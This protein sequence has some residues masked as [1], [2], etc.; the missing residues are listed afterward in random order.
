MI[1]PGVHH[2][3]HLTRR[4]DAL[5]EN[6]LVFACHSVRHLKFFRGVQVVLVGHPISSNYSE[7]FVIIRYEG[8][9]YSILSLNRQIHTKQRISSMAL[10]RNGPVKYKG[11]KAAFI[12]S[13]KSLQI[14]KISIDQF[15]KK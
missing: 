7:T 9:Q 2:S 14:L 10:P 4:T 1:M 5:N 12:L 8:I 15:R 13:F 3:T 6:Y 11:L